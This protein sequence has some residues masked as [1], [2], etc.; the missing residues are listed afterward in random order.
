MHNYSSIYWSELYG[1]KPVTILA[2]E[3]D[4]DSSHDNFYYNSTENKL[5]R[6]TKIS[7]CKHNII[8]KK[9]KQVNKQSC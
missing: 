5:Y 6:L 8:R 4:P 1:G 7:D 2:Y 9:W 3:P